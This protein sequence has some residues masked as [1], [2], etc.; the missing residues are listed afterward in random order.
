MVLIARS[1]AFVLCSFSGFALFSAPVALAVTPPVV[2]EESVLD[3]ADTSAT[4]QAKIDPEGSET[5]YRFEYGTS[6]AYGSKVPV[7]DGLVGSGSAGVTVSAHPQD[8][9]PAT[10]Y[11]YR[12]VAIVAS[13][14]ETIPGADGTFTTQPLGGK[15][16]LPD[17]RQWQL[18][19]PP[20]KYGAKIRPLPGFG[21]IQAAED[22]SAMTYQ[23]TVPTELEVPGY[24][25]EEQVLSMHGALGWSSRDMGLPRETVARVGECGRESWLF[26]PNLTSAL[27]SPVCQY[28]EKI[29]PPLSSEATEQ[30]P[31]IRREALCD[32]PSTARE[33][34]LPILTGK[35][36]LADVPPGTKFGQPEVLYIEGVSP[37][38]NH[39]AFKY[40]KEDV[41]EGLPGLFEWSANTPPSEAIQP[42]DVLPASEGGGTPTESRALVIGRFSGGP[43]TGNRHAISNDG[44]RV[45][46]A[47]GGFNGPLYVRDVRRRET[48]RLD[49]QQ[50]GVP[51]G[52]TPAAGFQIASA[53]GSKIFFTDFDEGQR[54]TPQSGTRGRDLYECEIV[55]EAGRLACKLTD[56]TPET[57]GQSAFAQKS[58][59]GASEDGSYVYFAAAGVL[60]DG[61]QRGA[62]QDSCPNEKTCASNIYEYHDGKV[63]FIAAGSAEDA[64]DWD[65]G[66]IQNLER[67]TARVSPDGRYVAFMS[68]SSLT[69]YDSRDAVSAQRDQEVYLY[70]ATS[71]R[72][73]CASC[74]P[75]GSRPTGVEAHEF[76]AFAKEPRQNIVGVTEVTEA[77][78][79]GIA[80]NI[81]PSNIFGGNGLYQPRAL[82]DGGR[83]FFNSSDALV[84]QDVNAQEDVYE[85]EPQGTGSCTAS[86][87]TF[88]RKAGGCVGLISSGTSPDESGFMDASSNGGDV[89][90]LTTS[91]LTAQD[92]DTSYDVYD[93]HECSPSVP[94]PAEP[95]GSPPCSSG[96]AC[97]GAPSPQPS[98]YG[99]PASAT[100][101]GAGNVVVQPNPIVRPRSLTRAQRLA[102]ALKGCRKKPKRKR[103]VC[104]KQA[105]KRYARGARRAAR[106]TGKARG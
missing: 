63:T 94:C 35:E 52:G 73:V 23:M 59:L 56:L 99:A 12:V 104:E 24:R 67:L 83:L 9:S 100:F 89:F 82:S 17:Q 101:S 92:Y 86:S 64:N 75:A 13:R 76:G 97:K 28:S 3:V 85:F 14:S 79:T 33:C 48:V 11:H 41:K 77:V 62:V 18:V 40:A 5:T 37:D 68:S 25:Q 2:E 90:F 65:G 95:V 54:L 29:S 80:A 78:P 43:P 20:N 106:A 55:E 93:A 15:L 72:L 10:E 26:S 46:W 50:P 91:R 42:I 74:N 32:T 19:T 96:D 38:L 8:L 16:E 27:V 102:T 45:V 1:F 4:L 34:Y 66:G 60:G 98:I 103:A 22:G 7:P 47:A 61:A 69:G 36:G 31:Y 39:V 57:E 81:A 6:E 70:D 44:S 49:V 71:K 21:P 30:T 53:D 105:R 88:D 58:V 51:S 87:A 84:S